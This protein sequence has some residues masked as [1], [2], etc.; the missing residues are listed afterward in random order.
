MIQFFVKWL[1]FA[2][3]TFYIF[4]EKFRNY[5]NEERTNILGLPI[6]DDFQKMTRYELC[7]FMDSGM[8]RRGFWDLNSTTKIRLGAQMLRNLVDNQKENK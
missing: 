4:I 6:D 3:G 5:P 2:V 8:P 7:S 1:L